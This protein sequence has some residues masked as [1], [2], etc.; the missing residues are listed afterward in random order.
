MLS[1]F[2][3]ASVTAIFNAIDDDSSLEC[4][5]N[6]DSAPNGDFNIRCKENEFKDANCKIATIRIITLFIMIAT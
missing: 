4:F 3:G 2:G 6:N 1:T 5:R